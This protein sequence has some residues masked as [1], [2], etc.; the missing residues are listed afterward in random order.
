MN[1]VLNAAFPLTASYRV[2]QRLERVPKVDADGRPET[3]EVAGRLV[4]ALEERPVEVRVVDER[5]DEDAQRV[6]EAH[7]L[8]V[9][10]AAV[11]ELGAVDARLS[12]RFHGTVDLTTWEG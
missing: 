8:E 3:T 5:L 12:T 4:V 11:R 10:S 6:R 1:L 7:V 9:L 2:E